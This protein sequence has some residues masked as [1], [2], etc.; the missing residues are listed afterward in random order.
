MTLHGAALDVSLSASRVDALLAAD[1]RDVGNEGV[2]LG[3]TL[4]ELAFLRKATID[5]VGRIPTHKEI[6]QYQQWPQAK[7]RTMLIDKLLKD[8]GFAD[9]WTV[10][11]ADLLRIRSRAEGGNR[12]LA[13]VHQSIDTGKSWDVMTRELIAASGSAGKSPSIGFLLADDSDPMEM[14]AA[15]GQIFMGVRMACAQCH[16]HPFDKWRQK[17]FYELAGFF[18][19]TRQVESRLSKKTY[20]TEG[21]EMK[22]LW[23]PERRKPKQRFPVAP[24]F[25]FPIQDSAVKPD[26]LKR[27]ESLR[28]GEINANKKQREA[29]ALD[30]LIDSADTSESPEAEMAGLDVARETKADIR[31][32][33]VQ[34]DLYRRSE[35]RAE[36]ARMVTHPQNRYFAR[37]LVNRVWGELLGRGFYMPIDDYQGEVTHPKT[38]KY[39]CDEFIANGY[40]VRFLLKTILETDAYARAALNTE[41]ENETRKS[42]QA[43][44]ASGIT[45]RMVSE[46]L[47]DSIVIAGHLQDYKWPKG[48][49]VRAYERRV[50]VPLEPEPDTTTLAET[51]PELDQAEMKKASKPK[52]YDLEQVISLDFDKLAASNLEQDL[53]QMKAMSDQELEAKQMAEMA[54]KKKSLRR[55]YTYKTVT[56]EVDDNPRFSSSMRMATPAAPTHFLRVF[57][58]PSRDGLGEFREHTPSMRQALMM[59]NGKATHEASRVGPY[60]PIYRLLTGEGKNLVKA[61]ELAYLETLTRRPSA[62]EQAEALAVLAQ[63]PLEGMADLRWALLNSHEFRYLP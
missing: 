51:E 46:V 7:R 14:A 6:L 37:N 11:F 50:R 55:R 21:D 49:N 17:Q 44:F 31:K 30:A 45:R 47:Y 58:Q 62:D 26:Y 4:D 27:L 18:G 54:R 60:E 28:T 2:A 34:G 19:K 52:P 57:G 9:R 24:K 5:M 41:A 32:L 56:E 63:A 59:L 23:P 40:N 13:Y 15:T 3:Q 8:N 25:P 53:G 29:D 12:L 35:L 39:L 36:L 38:V 33:N 20:V 48:A 1:N 61:V 16:N 43:A 42:S 10:F 22:V